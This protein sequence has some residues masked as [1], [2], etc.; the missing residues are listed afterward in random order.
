MLVFVIPRRELKMPSLSSFLCETTCLSW[1]TGWWASTRHMTAPSLWPWTLGSYLRGSVTGSGRFIT[2]ISMN[3]P[4]VFCFFI[5]VDCWPCYSV[6]IIIHLL[7][8]QGQRCRRNDIRIVTNMCCLPPPYSSS[9]SSTHYC[10]IYHRLNIHY[11]C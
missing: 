10:G 1:L 9:P 4:S 7:E 2:L 3:R 6:G 11:Y 5:S 8:S